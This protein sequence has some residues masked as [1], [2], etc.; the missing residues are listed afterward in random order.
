MSRVSSSVLRWVFHK[1]NTYLLWKCTMK[2]EGGLYKFV[3]KQFIVEFLDQ[4]PPPSRQLVVL[5]KNLRLLVACWVHWN[6]TIHAKTSIFKYGLLCRL[7]SLVLLKLPHSDVKVWLTPC[8]FPLLRFFD[9]MRREGLIEA[10]TLG[11]SSY[12]PVF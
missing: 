5:F 11:E 3:R 1:I 8:T 4:E 6:P 7:L 12:P 2:V 9:F 10:Q